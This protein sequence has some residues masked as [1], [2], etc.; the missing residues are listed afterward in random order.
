MVDDL[1]H[2]VTRMSGPIEVPEFERQRR[3]KLIGFIIS[4]A[5]AVGV[6]LLA[7]TLALSS[8]LPNPTLALSMNILTIVAA[9]VVAAI[10]IIFFALVPTLPR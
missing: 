3:S 8:P 9:V 10:P 4:E 1:L 6:L 2:D 7:G 5:S